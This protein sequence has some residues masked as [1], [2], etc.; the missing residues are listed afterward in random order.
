MAKM[1]ATAW[2]LLLLL[3][4][5]GDGT[6]KDNPNSTDTMDSGTHG[7]AATGHGDGDGD[8]P[9]MDSGADS[10]APDAAP[11]DDAGSDGSLRDADQPDAPIDDASAEHDAGSDAG[12]VTCDDQN[13]ATE[14]VLDATF[15]CGVRI[16]E[17]WARFKAQDGS[18]FELD[19]LHSRIWS[20]VLVE[21][22]KIN[23]TY[24]EVQS[25]CAQLSFRGFSDFRIPSID[26]VRTLASGCANT[27]VGGS[28]PLSSADECTSEDCGYQSPACT[29]CIGG[30]N[31][32]GPHNR[33]YCRAE[34]S[35]C[36]VGW[37]ST[38][39]SDCPAGHRWFY[40]VINGN[41]YHSDSALNPGRCVADLP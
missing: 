31:A 20:P 35:A 25:H 12:V 18:V 2:T 21:G 22:A 15:G 40:G 5:C 10:Q 11:P 13:S 6:S 33:Q 23:Y 3:A 29:S 38:E 30:P 8:N 1:R 7:D 32:T 37:T 26:D 24:A 4:G 41:F 19:Y 17:N 9:S 39:C 34:L 27:V 16:S 14:D 36:V 28:C